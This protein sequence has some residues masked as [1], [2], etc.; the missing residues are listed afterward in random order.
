M[1]VTAEDAAGDTLAT[2]TN[3]GQL[4]ASPLVFNDRVGGLDPSDFYKFSINGLK[5]VTV[6]VT[7]LT[8]ADVDLELLDAQGNPV[9]PISANPGAANEQV[10]VQLLPGTYIAHVQPK[11][12]EG[13]YTISMRANSVFDFAKNTLATARDL[14]TLGNGTDITRHEYVGPDDT[15]DIYKFKL[16]R[17]SN[18]QT[19]LTSG[20]NGVTTFLFRDTNGDGAIQSTEKLSNFEEMVPGLQYYLVVQR[21]TSPGTFYDARIRVNDIGDFAGNS[22]QTAHNV[23]TLTPSLIT[24]DDYVGAEDHDDFYKIHVNGGDT[25]H[26]KLD[27]LVGNADLVLYDSG[28]HQIGYF[29]KSGTN[30]ESIVVSVSPIAIFGE[31]FFVRVERVGTANTTFQLTMHT[32]AH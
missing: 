24:F 11:V 5:N 28:G 8:T 9:A 14:G 29:P 10:H 7:G 6:S 21:T 19:Q 23:G 32:D 13:P 30:S 3:V 18:V 4:T 27:H 22:I 15:L 1:A 16:S 2:A 12:G 26:L 31:D 20:A 25:A 17:G